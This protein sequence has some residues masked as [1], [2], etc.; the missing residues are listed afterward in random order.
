M[1]KISWQNHEYTFA[2]LTRLGFEVE[3]GRGVPHDSSKCTLIQ[4]TLIQ[5]GWLTICTVEVWS[6][7]G[8]GSS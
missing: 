4:F 8:M 1:H 3:T 6:L 7:L 2:S 5:V